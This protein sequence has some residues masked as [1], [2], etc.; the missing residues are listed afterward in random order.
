MYRYA[1]LDPRESNERVFEDATG[2]VLGVEVTIPALAARCDL[3][4]LDPQHTDHQ[5]VAACVAAL[6]CHLPPSGATL[7]TNRADA[8]SLLAMAVLTLRAQGVEDWSVAKVVLVGQADAA[9]SGPWVKDYSPPVEFAQAS[10]V[11]MDHRVP[12]GDRVA[13]LMG[14]LTGWVSLPD[15][16]EVDR[17]EIRVKRSA[18]SQYAVVHADGPA[19][20]GACAAGYQVAPIVVAANEGFRLAGGEPH[21]KYTIAR[22]NSGVAMDWDGMLDELRALEPGW[23][24]SDSICGSTQGVGSRLTMGEVRRVVERHLPKSLRE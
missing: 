20:R 2:G 1:L 24:G 14:W 15:V 7:V 19:G 12:V 6:S 22:W 13:T 9:P 18:C 23:G 16:P 11:A 17:S 4:N 21:R 8:D 10:A 3:G 5:D